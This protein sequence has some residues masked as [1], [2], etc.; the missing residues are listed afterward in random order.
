MKH[1]INVKPIVEGA[2]TLTI[3]TNDSQCYTKPANVP[4]NLQVNKI[5]TPSEL[6]AIAASGQAANSLAIGD[7]FPVVFNGALSDGLT[8]SNE[9]YYA[10]LIGID[11]NSS[12]EGTKRLHFKCPY[13]EDGTQLAFCDNK[14][15]EP[16]GY[17][18]AT[19]SGIYFNM[20]NA[21][22]ASNCKD[23]Y[24]AGGYIGSNMKK[25]VMPR[26]KSAMESG[27]RNVIRACTKYSDNNTVSPGTTVSDNAANVTASQEDLWLLDE[28]EYHG[29]RTYA[30]SASQNY[31]KQYQCYINGNSK[32][33]YGHDNRTS[34][35]YVWARGV[36]VSGYNTFCYVYSA[37]SAN[38]SY[39]AYSNGV[40]FGF[41]L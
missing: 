10:A 13:S 25:N 2:S 12:R 34:V 6:S 22:S 30:N 39:A 36:S 3:T 16:I 37:G 7:L 40:A 18:R 15:G 27:W 14:Y 21:T 38:H 8:L 33:H 31:Q 26:I 17:K 28:Y 19:T 41:T 29:T 20:N 5:L 35:T 9:T 4:V 24:N 23:G 11:H 32:I 1:K